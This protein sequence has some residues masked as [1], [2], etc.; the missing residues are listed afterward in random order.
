MK[1]ELS[2]Y[3]GMEL[4]ISISLRD[5][6]RKKYERVNPMPSLGALQGTHR[7]RYL[8][9]CF[10][11]LVGHVGKIKVVVPPDGY[12]SS[13]NDEGSNRKRQKTTTGTDPAFVLQVSLNPSMCVMK[14]RPR[15]LIMIRSPW[16]HSRASRTKK[17]M[18][19]YPMPMLTMLTGMP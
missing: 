15:H 9:R 13:R 10:V 8:V 6:S 2:P 1:R 11:C 3:R 12:R 16:T 5:K 7:F 14:M 18:F 17:S 4:L 19:G